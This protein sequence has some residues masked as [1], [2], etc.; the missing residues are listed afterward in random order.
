[1][2]WLRRVS[3]SGRVPQLEE[4]LLLSLL[5]I[6][7]SLNNLRMFIPLDPS[8]VSGIWDKLLHDLI[9]NKSCLFICDGKK[10]SEPKCQVL[11]EERAKRIATKLR[12]RDYVRI[13]S[14][15]LHPIPLYFGVDIDAD[16]GRLMDLISISSDED[17]LKNDVTLLC[18][19]TFLQNKQMGKLIVP[20][21]LSSLDDPELE[22]AISPSGSETVVSRVGP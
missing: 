18:Q 8:S 4:R 2:T 11:S 7:N 14:G 10:S 19:L 9:S 1:M 22:I 20:L 3:A 12:S 21:V 13:G 6:R 17:R 15:R 5:L 16:S